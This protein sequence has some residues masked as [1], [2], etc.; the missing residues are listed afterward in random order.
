LNY[1]FATINKFGAIH[2]VPYP[3]ILKYGSIWHRSKVW[4]E[5][6]VDIPR[7]RQIAKII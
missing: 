1:I 7:Y 6:G 2:K 4:I 5:S 3:W